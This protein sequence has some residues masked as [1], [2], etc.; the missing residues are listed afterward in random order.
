MKG[1]GCDEKL[2]LGGPHREPAVGGG[3]DEAFGDEEREPDAEVRSRE[4][5]TN[6][7]P[8]EDHGAAAPEE[9]GESAD[10]AGERTAG[11][12]FGGE[13]ERQQAEGGNGGADG[14]VL[15]DREPP[16][17][18][19]KRGEIFVPVG[20]DGREARGDKRDEVKRAGEAHA[21]NPK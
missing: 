5:R 4:D 2:T 1:R 12:E 8:R 9:R 19:R 11:D 16:V 6:P 10:G 15:R 7:D 14:E 20:R 17:D 3:V 21:E 18:R 13:D